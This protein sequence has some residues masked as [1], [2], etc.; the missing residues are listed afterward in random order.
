MFLGCGSFGVCTERSSDGGFGGA[1]IK[2][3]YAFGNTEAGS[4]KKGSYGNGVY[5]ECGNT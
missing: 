4:I 1:D 5:G 2:K 3:A